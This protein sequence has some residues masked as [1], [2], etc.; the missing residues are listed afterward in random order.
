MRTNSAERAASHRLIRPPVPRAIKYA[1]IIGS[2]TVVTMPDCSNRAAR[3]HHS[4]RAPALEKPKLVI[5]QGKDSGFLRTL[6]H[7]PRFFSIHRHR[8]FA[9]HCLALFKCGKRHLHVRR[10]WRDDTD[11]LN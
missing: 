10:R 3:Q 4:H 2:E 8:L 11:K 5:D 1:T 9:K 6:R 7:A